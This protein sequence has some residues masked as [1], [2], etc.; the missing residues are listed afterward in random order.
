M[1]LKEYTK[2]VKDLDEKFKVERDVH[3]TFVQMLEEIGELAKEINR[4]KLR[5]TEIDKENLKGE[6]A[7]IFLQFLMLAELMGVDL[8]GAV[9]YKTKALKERHELP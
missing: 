9:E 8:E 1:D 4:P 3:L 2:I 6:F 7:D 5:H